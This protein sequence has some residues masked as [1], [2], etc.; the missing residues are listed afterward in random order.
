MVRRVVMM[1]M[2]D[3]AA[4]V[5]PASQAPTVSVIYATVGTTSSLVCMTELVR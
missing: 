5:R 4:V 3:T 2:V 1:V